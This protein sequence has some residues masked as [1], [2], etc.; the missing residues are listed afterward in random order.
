MKKISQ[1]LTILTILIVLFSNITIYA[2]KH[3][4]SWQMDALKGTPAYL[5][6]HWDYIETL[7]FDGVVIFPANY[8]YQAIMQPGQTITYNEIY[9]TWRLGELS[10]KFN[11]V[12][13]NYLISWCRKA[14]FFD[15]A[16]WPTIVQNFAN[17][18]KAAKDAGIA[19]I[20]FD[21]EQ[22][23]ENPWN[24]PSS[25]DHSGTYSLEQYRTQVR[26]RGKQVMAA[27]IAEFPNIEL[28]TSHGPYWSEPTFNQ[29]FLPNPVYDD[30][31]L[32]GSFFAGF[33][34]AVIDAKAAGHSPKAI[35][36]GE[37]YK[38]RTI[39]E[40]EDLYQFRKNTMPSAAN[41]SA[42]I[43]VSLRPL[44]PANVNISFGTYNL[45][46]EAPMD[47]SIMRTTFEYATRRADDIV[48]L[49]S[50]GQ[51][52]YVSGGVSTDWINAIKDGFIAGTSGE[53][54]G[55]PV[56]YTYCAEE[57]QSFTLMGICDV[58][59]GANGQFSYLY[60]QTGSITYTNATFGGDPIPGVA[61]KGYYKTSSVG[62]AGYTYCAEETQSFNLTGT[63]DVAFGANGTFNYLYNKTGTITFNV[64]TFGDPIPGVA[65]KGY[66]KTS[67]VG[68]AGY[69]YCAEETQSYTFTGTCDV[70]FGANGTFNYL[71]GKTGSITFNVATFGDPIPGVAKKGYYKTTSVTNLII[72]YGI[73]SVLTTGWTLDWGSSSRSSTY[74]KSGSYSLKISAQGGRAQNITSGFTVGS[75]YTL[76]AWGRGSSAL[77]V[78]ANIGVICYNGTTNIA[79]FIAPSYTTTTFVQQLVTFTVPANT[80]T[81][82]IY[83][84]FNGSGTKALYVDDLKLMSGT[85]KSANITT[86]ITNSITDEI[87]VYPNPAT[88]NITNSNVPY[89][90][91]I[92]AFTMDGKMVSKIKA[93]NNS[94]NFDVSSWKKGI[95]LLKVQS[96]SGV[97]VKKII[98]E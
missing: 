38:P 66:Y 64:A 46:N 87:S 47:P 32:A 53:V 82:Q 36:G 56:G 43:P 68:P 14:E 17:L 67:S 5:I 97:V 91:N 78:S 79:E 21:N 40:F 98:V 57:G 11:K 41:N 39:Q 7:P 76:S 59:Y 3:C 18:A 61:K 1:K 4:I 74:K 48:W 51:D 69:T 54:G 88:S 52:W 92:A 28:M 63:C 50:E 34:E 35:D 15:D 94:I 77:A 10:A 37:F 71:Y 25:V 44:W 31:E 55:G 95:Y 60:G 29:Q 19:G 6:D 89:N 27:M 22:Y 49:Y 90:T 45:G 30:G 2:Q 24:Y 65:K 62:P 9:T 33:V 8:R 13:H 80:T 81:L 96:E 84:W 16:I 42:Q 26:L 23:I 93:D 70:A 83:V 73:E 12:K 86:E 58:A 75:Q 72:N 85:Q 20:I